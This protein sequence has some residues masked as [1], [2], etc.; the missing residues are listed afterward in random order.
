MELTQEDDF[1]YQIFYLINKEGSYQMR[2][3]DMLIKK[4]N[5]SDRLQT[6]EQSVENS[7]I[8]LIL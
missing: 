3:L 6:L 8:V 1:D 5:S 7:D 4:F 2:E